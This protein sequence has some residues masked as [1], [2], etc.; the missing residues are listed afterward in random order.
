MA[1]ERNVKREEKTMSAHRNLLDRYVELYNAGDLDACMELYA[2]DAVQRM[3]DGTFAGRSAIRERLARDLT[4]CPDAAYT[5][6]SFVEQGD[7]FADEWTFAGTQTGPLSLPDGTQLPPTGKRLEI[8]G[9]ELVQVRD[10]KIVIDN[11]YYDAMAV[12]AQLGVIPQG[13][14][15]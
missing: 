14:S 2:E 6:G 11:L 7:S 9:M 12:L 8:K 4:A 5:V 10:G 3:H 1:V 15:A 13:A